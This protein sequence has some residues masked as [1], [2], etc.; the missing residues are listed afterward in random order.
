MQARA[1]GSSLADEGV[2]TIE[3][4]CFGAGAE[5][6]IWFEFPRVKHTKKPASADFLKNTLD[7]IRTNDLPLRRSKTQL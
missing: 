7:W 4:V 1:G 6:Q 2:G 3:P 5:K